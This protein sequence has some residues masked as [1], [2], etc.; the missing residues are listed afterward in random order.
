MDD[1]TYSDH[2]QS[3]LLGDQ[4]AS[5]NAEGLPNA[6]TSSH[7]EIYRAKRQ[8]GVYYTPS[9]VA[10]LLVS[11][12][13]RSKHDLILEP[14][15]GGC[16][17][18]EASLTRLRIMGCDAPE[19]QLSGFDID[20]QAF[21]HLAKLDSRLCEPGNRFI[22][23]DFLAASGNDFSGH[24]SDVIVANPPFVPY[25]RMNSVQRKAIEDWSNAHPSV[26][27]KDS[28]LWAYFLQ[29]ALQFLKSG[30]RMAWILPSSLLFVEYGHALRALI[31]SHFKTTIFIDLQEQLF[32]ESGTRERTVL[33]FSERFSAEPLIKSEATTLRFLRFSDVADQFEKTK[34]LA[35]SNRWPGR[36]DD[37]VEK[38]AELI[39][40]ALANTPHLTLGDISNIRIGD[41]VGDISYFVNSRS[42]W[43]LLGIHEDELRPLLT[44]S[45]HIKGIH[46]TS[47]LVGKLVMNESKCLLL[48]PSSEIPSQA[49]TEYLST[50]PTSKRESNATFARRSTWFISSYD[51]TAD[52]FFPSL[53]TLGP[54]FIVNSCGLACANSLYKIHLNDEWR[55]AKFALALYG[56]S[57][58]AQL[59][60]ELIGGAM[61]E[62][63]L[64][65]NPS[66]LKQLPV[67]SDLHSSNAN[68]YDTFLKVDQF[69]TCGQLKDARDLADLWLAPVFSEKLS[70]QI[71]SVLDMVRTRRRDH[72]CGY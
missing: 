17:F 21:I 68:T 16:A 10:D 70:T 71:S 23:G 2:L 7:D 35:T 28:S 59:S 27:P 67:I 72:R 50:Y 61:G 65:L 3:A 8:H 29:H 18:L 31:Q 22:Q 14:S 33:V 13:I 12:A 19:Q 64:K 53:S 47:S 41:V 4:V 40:E 9:D 11:W 32:I 52:L 30:G 69:I 43:E 44:K 39:A 1:L 20:P 6:T 60:A 42:A 66:H 37:P 51:G 58:F 15:F 45:S 55:P 62:G 57:S 5:L 24:K 46:A 54:R 56:A 34:T 49:A 48:H 36:S 63:A 38:S 25:R 26:V